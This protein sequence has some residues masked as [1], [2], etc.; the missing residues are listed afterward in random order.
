MRKTMID[1]GLNEDD[2]TNATV[3]TTTMA[4]ETEAVIEMGTDEDDIIEVGMKR[5]I[6]IEKE[7][8]GMMRLMKSERRGGGDEG[9]EMIGIEIGLENRTGHI[10]GRERGPR[11]LVA[12]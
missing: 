11:G 10:L 12:L 6:E 2:E 5:L 7:E 9:R 8:G 1:L 4:N 3:I